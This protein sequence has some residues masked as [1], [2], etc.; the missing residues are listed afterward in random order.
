MQQQQPPQPNDASADSPCSSASS[1]STLRASLLR[2]LTDT[3]AVI[4]RLADLQD[5]PHLHSSRTR[6]ACVAIILRIKHP[7]DPNYEPLATPKPKIKKQRKPKATAA[8][9]PA[10]TAPAPAGAAAA[11]VTTDTPNATAAAIPA[12]LAVASQAQALS[13]AAVPKVAAAAT[14]S[15]PPAAAAAAAPEADTYTRRTSSIPASVAAA[16]RSRL[17]ALAAEPWVQQSSLEVLFMQ[18]AL[19]PTDRWRFVRGPTAHQQRRALARA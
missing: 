19:N 18:R 14:G 8:A 11:S 4:A 12:V 6:R 5:R 10:A 9:G 16:T 2:S 7:D 17:S 15:A 13:P 3:A 1:A